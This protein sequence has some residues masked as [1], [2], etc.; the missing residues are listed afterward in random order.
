[1]KVFASAIGQHD[2]IGDTVLRRGFLDVLRSAGPLHVYVGSQGEDQLSA[3]G[4]AEGDTLY[5]SSPE[6]RSA[7]SGTFLRGPAVY[8]FDTGEAELTKPFAQRYLRLAPLLLANRVRGGSAVHVGVGLR[9]STPWRHPIGAVLRLCDLVTWRDAFSREV[10]GLGS[11]TPDWAFRLGAGEAELRAEVPRDVLA[12]AV[13]SSLPHQPRP[14]PGE[15]W[16]EAVARLAEQQ[17][18]RPVFVA[19]IARDGDLAER[20]A[21]AAGGECLLWESA[22][23]ADFEA[24]LRQLYRRSAVV[25]SDRL[26]GLVIAATE[27]ASPVALAVDPLDKCTRTLAAVGLERGTRV[28]PG[29]RDADAVLATARQVRAQTVEAVLQARRRLDELAERVGALAGDGGRSR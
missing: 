13:R 10:V 19:Q 23:H 12:V 29:L 5:R 16:A 25:L 21:K 7:L 24:R 1:M 11:V 18:L 22:H 15:E 2:N 26:H 9:R 20:L 28:E 14:E 3:L 27:G 8:A 4:L 17:G 6:W